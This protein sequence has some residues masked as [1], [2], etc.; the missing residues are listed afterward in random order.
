MKSRTPGLRHGFT[1]IELLVVIAVVAI[2]AAIL[3]PVLIGTK[4]AARESKCLS[5]LRQIGVAFRSYMAEWD[6]RYMPAAGYQYN[7]PGRCFVGVLKPYAR[8]DRIFLCPSGPAKDF[9]YYDTAL[10]NQDDANAPDSGW[11][12]DPWDPYWF[13]RDRTSRSHYGNNILLGGGNPDG[14]PDAWIRKIATDAEVREP[15]RVIYLVDAR[16]VDLAGG[17][18]VGRIGMARERHH[19]GCNTVLCDGHSKWISVRELNR[20]FTSKTGTFRWDYR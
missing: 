18:H 10:S 9:R 15:A 11:K 1:L 7:W 8:S 19:G 5:N 3:Y 16:W 2:V 12:W 13:S 4:A 6:E 20:S 17:W 14:T